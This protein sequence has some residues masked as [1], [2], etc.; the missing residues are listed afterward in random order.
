MEDQRIGGYLVYRIIDYGRFK[1][2][3]LL[4]IMYRDQTE[5]KKIIRGFFKLS[6]LDNAVAAIFPVMTNKLEMKLFLRAGFYNYVFKDDIG[7][8]GMLLPKG[9]DDSQY[10]FKSPFFTMGDGL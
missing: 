8:Y 7:L 9:V 5:L 1:V 10:L 3:S 4:D 6:S 2:A